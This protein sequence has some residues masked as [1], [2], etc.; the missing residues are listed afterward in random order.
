MSEKSESEIVL[1]ELTNVLD[2]KGIEYELEVTKEPRNLRFTGLV[3]DAKLTIGFTELY[4]S[5]GCYVTMQ[6]VSII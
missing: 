5:K 3:F 2:K 4:F 1:F 6:P